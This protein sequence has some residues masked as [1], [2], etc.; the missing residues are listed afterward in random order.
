MY[1]HLVEEPGEE[2]VEPVVEVRLVGGDQLA[3]GLQEQ[4]EHL[5]GD[6]GDG[7]GGGAPWCTMLVMVVV[8]TLVCASMNILVKMSVMR[9]SSDPDSILGNHSWISA[10]S[11][12]V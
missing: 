5:T 8:A 10:L 11:R 6:G 3:Q 2:D 4:G 9:R 1:Y 12:F 7:G